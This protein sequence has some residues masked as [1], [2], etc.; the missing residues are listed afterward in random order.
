[1]FVEVL[2]EEDDPPELELELEEELDVGVG[3]GVGVEEAQ[4]C[5]VTVVLFKVIAPF[6]AKSLPLTVELP[7]SVID[8]KASIFPI[9]VVDVPRV[10]E[11]PT[12][13]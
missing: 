10:A 2:V 8:V 5:F 1:M 7:S 11:D 9:R 3:V 13:Q 12:C 4:V 6:L